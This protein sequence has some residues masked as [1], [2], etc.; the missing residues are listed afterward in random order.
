[1]NLYYFLKDFYTW[2]VKKINNENKIHVN[3]TYAH[4]MSWREEGGF[5]NFFFIRMQI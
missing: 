3:A 2:Q 1:M 5:S 4:L